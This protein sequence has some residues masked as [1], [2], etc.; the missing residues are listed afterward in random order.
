MRGHNLGDVSYPLG[1]SSIKI[2]Y[3]VY[4][5]WIHDQLKSEVDELVNLQFTP[6][7]SLYA[8]ANDS[9]AIFIKISTV[10]HEYCRIRR[11]T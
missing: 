6:K 3:D 4:A 2:T 1:H 8:P 7:R 11:W 5:H 9:S 10:F